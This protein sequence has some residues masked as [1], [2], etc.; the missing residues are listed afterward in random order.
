M[1][2]QTYGE[3]I[4]TEWYDG[5]LRSL[6]LVYFEDGDKRVEVDTMLAMVGEPYTIGRDN[7]VRDVKVRFDREE[8]LKM[9]ALLDGEAIKDWNDEMRTSDPVKEAPEQGDAPCGS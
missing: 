3:T 9:L 8:L 4:T 2:R 7:N 5:P 1:T 6:R